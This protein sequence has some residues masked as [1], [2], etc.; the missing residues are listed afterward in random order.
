M[1]KTNEELIE[2]FDRLWGYEIDECI[3]EHKAL[4]G[5]RDYHFSTLTQQSTEAYERGV[6]AERGKRNGVIKEYEDE[7]VMFVLKVENGYT[8]EA[9]M[10]IPKWVGVGKVELRDT[11][12]L[13]DQDTDWPYT[14]DVEHNIKVLEKK[15]GLDP[16]SDQED[17]E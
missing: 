4:I 15:F 7:G 2:E 9:C 3:K 6:A 13:S 17:K 5:L 16:L 14:E 12:P 10:P 11:T 1:N 8:Y